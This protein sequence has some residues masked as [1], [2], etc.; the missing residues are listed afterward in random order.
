[1]WILGIFGPIKFCKGPIKIAKC[2][3]KFG[4]LHVFELDK[5][6]WPII[7][8]HHHFGPGLSL[9]ADLNLIWSKTANEDFLVSYIVGEIGNRIYEF[10]TVCQRTYQEA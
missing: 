6:H 3:L 5:S 1:M 8:T 9:Q 4:N 10:I 2:P 7:R